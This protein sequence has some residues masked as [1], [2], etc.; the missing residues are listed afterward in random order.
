MPPFF[1]TDNKAE[2]MKPEGI[3]SLAEDVDFECYMS[4][5]AFGVLRDAVTLAKLFL[6]KSANGT[7]DPLPQID[8]EFGTYAAKCTAPAV[9]AL[10]ENQS[11]IQHSLTFRAAITAAI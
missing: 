4:V 11:E 1:A 9:I 3:L 10:F 7:I 6:R 5:V 2:T 8:Q